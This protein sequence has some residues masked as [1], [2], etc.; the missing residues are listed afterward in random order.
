MRL[1]KRDTEKVTRRILEKLNSGTIP[2]KRPYKGGLAPMNITTG[3]VYS[4]VNRLVTHP[5]VSGYSSPLWITHNAAKQWKDKDGK[6]T[7]GHVRPGEKATYIVVPREI[8]DKSTGEVKGIHFTTTWVFNVE[9]CENLDIEEAEARVI[10]ENKSASQ[11]I[12][13]YRQMPPVRVMDC[14][15][16]YA[17]RLDEIRMPPRENF[18]SDN[19]YY[20][21]LF[22]EMAHSTGHDKRL[23]RDLKSFNENAHAY[24]KE[25]LIAEITSAYLCSHCGIDAIEN[26]AAYI[27]GWRSKLSDHPEIILE[28]ASDAD[29]AYRYILQ[30]EPCNGSKNKKSPQE[31]D[32][33][34]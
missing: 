10:V 32:Q 4:G 13:D 19:E 25:E 11:L 16:G 6:K 31:E 5:M 1:S 3:T 33:E 23:A 21:T 12:G 22:H 9:Q 20:A 27:D 24:S 18:H 15:P 26:S 34:S 17:P 2:W 7:G 14:T 29:Q 30:E 8:K 28:A